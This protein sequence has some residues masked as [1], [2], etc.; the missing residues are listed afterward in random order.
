MPLSGTS[1][2][3]KKASFPSSTACANVPGAGGSADARSR[4]ITS[5]VSRFRTDTERLTSLFTYARR[6]SALTT[7]PFGMLPVRNR[8][9]FGA[10]SVSFWFASRA[11]R[12][13]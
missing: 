8:I 3:V 7:M 5:L 11:A 1:S 13:T 10:F 9:T 6:P 4:V 12:I 2:A